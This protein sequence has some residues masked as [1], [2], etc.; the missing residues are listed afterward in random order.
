MKTNYVLTV[1]LC[2]ILFFSCKKNNEAPPSFPDNAYSYRAFI[3]NSDTLFK[4][5]SAFLITTNADDEIATSVEC[6]INDM[7]YFFFNFNEVGDKIYVVN[8]DSVGCL[9]SDHCPVDF[10]PIAGR[11]NRF[12]VIP[13]SWVKY[14]IIDDLPLSP[15]TSAV[16]IINSEYLGAYP[17]ETI[18]PEG[19]S[20]I[21]PV[22]GSADR[23]FTIR[24]R[25]GGSQW[26]HISLP[27]RWISAFDT[28]TITI[29]Y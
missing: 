1:F 14:R 23:S 3:R 27:S 12:D 10:N 6:P 11:L 29:T 2:S 17:P 13:R 28:T 24:Y 21:R 7:G 25:V 5:G 9:T 4:N 26:E 8:G 20:V 19:D 15:D 16:A 18:I 22:E